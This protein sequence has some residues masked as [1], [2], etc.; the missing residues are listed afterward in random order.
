MIASPSTLLALLRTVEH[1]WRI[2]HQNQNTRQIAD[3]GG[4]LYDQFVLLRRVFRTL[5]KI[6][7]SQEAFE[8]AGQRLSIGRG[9]LVGRAEKL[10]KLGVSSTKSADSASGS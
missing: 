7:R 3:L 1:V 2:E 10:K 6:R 9:N 5:V 4:K 8:K